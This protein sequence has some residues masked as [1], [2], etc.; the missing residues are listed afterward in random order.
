MPEKSKWPHVEAEEILSRMFKDYLADP[1]H[2]EE[3]RLMNYQLIRDDSLY[4]IKIVKLLRIIEDVTLLI[5]L[6]H[7]KN[8][9]CVSK[10]IVQ[11]VNNFI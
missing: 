6:M 8:K 1:K 10:T 11:A 3:G 4:A 9:A 7:I 5:L 2:V